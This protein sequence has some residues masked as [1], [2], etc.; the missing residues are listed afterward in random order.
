MK[1]DN[2]ELI[3]VS[4]PFAIS[5]SSYHLQSISDVYYIDNIAVSTKIA[6]ITA[7]RHYRASII[8]TNQQLRDIVLP[9]TIYNL[10]NKDNINID[11]LT[12]ITIDNDN[13]IKEVLSINYNINKISSNIFKNEIDKND[14]IGK[15]RAI[16]R[17]MDR[18]R[19]LKQTYYNMI[20][21]T[22][23]YSDI[24]LIYR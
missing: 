21:I 11:D 1:T 23:I 24:Y 19:E 17:A 14:K 8:L 22:N 7:M 3:H 13:K 18:N 12:S 4:L 6:H 5:I 9:T 20:N 15:V 2:S 16:A 10:S